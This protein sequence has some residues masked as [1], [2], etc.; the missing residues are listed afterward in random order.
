MPTEIFLVVSFGRQHY[1]ALPS[2]WMD[3]EVA[4]WEGRNKSLD[5]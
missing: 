1:L 3:W 2:H 4:G 5:S